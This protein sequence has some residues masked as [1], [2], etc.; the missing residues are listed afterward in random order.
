MPEEQNPSLESRKVL[1]QDQAAEVVLKLWN[2][3][4]KNTQKYRNKIVDWYKQYRGIP[5]RKHYQGL[6]NVF[7]NETLSAVES[8]VAQIYQ[9]LRIDPT[10][11]YAKPGEET[12]KKIVEL[13]EELV[14]SSLENMSFDSKLLQ[15]IRQ[16]VKYGTTVAKVYKRLETKPGF[17]RNVSEEMGVKFSNVQESE[18]ITYDDVDIEYIDLMDVAFDPGKQNVE[19]MDWVIIRRRVTMDDLKAKQRQGLYGN[20]DKISQPSGTKNYNQN[21]KEK[22]L[23]AI[24]ITQTQ[25]LDMLELYEFWGK[26]PKYWIDDELDLNSPEAEEMVEA[27]IEVVG[28]VIVRLNFNPYWHQQKPIILARYIA[29]DDE[30]YGIGVCEILEYLQEELNAKRNQALDAVTLRI[31]PPL[32]KLRS[33][34]IDNRDVVMT[35]RKI[36]PSDVK[37]GINPLNAI[38]EISSAS[39]LENVVKQDM[40]NNSG[41]TASVQGLTEKGEQTA[42]EVNVLQTR[43]ASRI[44]VASIDFANSFLRPL[45]KMIYKIHQQYTTIEKVV[46]RSGKKGIRWIKWTPEDVAID[47]DFIPVVPTDIDNRIIVRNQMIQFIGQIAKFYPQVNAYK[48]VRKIYTLFGFE[49]ADEI[50]PEPDTEKGQADLSPEEEIILLEMGQKIDVKFW[51]NHFQKL[52]SLIP[53]LQQNQKRLTQKAIDTF[54]DKINQHQRYLTNL[55]QSM[56]NVIPPPG[57]SAPAGRGQIAKPQF[58]ASHLQTPTTLQRAAVSGGI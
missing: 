27:V 6:A 42:F 57:A 23:T 44:N 25:N 1:V 26:A 56:Q 20:V 58:E 14:E 28:N 22:K 40:H 18:I 50:V 55:E 12:D 33:A 51:E 9:T 36:I 5:N 53:Y 19:S 29:V 52:S 7:V 35:P 2:D 48:M 39:L 32:E 4:L 31:F 10:S 54:Q 45:Y 47:F 43:G 41:A 21:D 24:G 3:N 8:I 49:D 38:G 30:A 11:F 46:A 15:H 13:G 34:N 17:K 37:G 16:A